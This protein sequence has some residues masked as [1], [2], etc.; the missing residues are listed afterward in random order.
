MRRTALL[1][2]FLL[3]VLT[4][5]VRGQSSGDIFLQ[6]R[7]AWDAGDY[8]SALEGF[9]EVLRGPGESDHREE[10]ALITGELYPV[11]AIAP[12]GRSLYL[13]PGGRFAAWNAPDDGDTRVVDISD[14]DRTVYEGAVQGLVFDHGDRLAAIT[15]VEEN[16]P[17]REARRAAN[18]ARQSG[19][20]RAYYQALGEVRRLEAVQARLAVLDLTTGRLHRV[21]LGGAIPTG[22]VFA[23]DGSALYIT[24]V[25]GQDA[26]HGVVLSVAADGRGPVTMVAEGA[27]YPSDPVALAGGFVAYERGPR[28]SVQG[29]GVPAAGLSRGIGL[30]DISRGVERMLPGEDPVP[31]GD[32]RTLVW[33]RSREAG[34]SF[35][36]LRA[37]W[38]GE[39]SVF[40]E[41]AEDVSSPTLSPSGDRMVFQMMA[42]HNW[43]LYIVPTAGGEAERLTYE[44]QHD[45][46]PRFLDEGTVFA[47][48]GE[49]RHRRSYLYDAADGSRR[50]LFHN[51][52]VRT[53]A[54]EYEWQVSSDGMRIL[55]GSERD[56]DTVSPERGVY[57]VDRSRTLGRE[58]ILKRVNA[59][60]ASERELQE[61][62][63]TMYAPIRERVAEVTEQVSMTM[64]YD[65]QADLY[66]FDSK[67]ITMP[68]NEPATR[69]IYEK[70]ASFGYEPEYHRFEV[71]RG[72]ET[73]R[74][75]NVLA[76]LEGTEHPEVVYVVSSHFDS[77]R[78]GPGADDNSTGAAVILE[79]ARVM[80]DQPQPATIVFAAFNGEEAG[81]LG[82]RA[83]V[84]HAVDNGLNL[85]GALNNDMFGWSGDH[86]LDNTIRYSN[87]GIRDVQHGAA[88]LFSGLITYDALYYKSTDAAA[89]YEAYG[90]IVGGIG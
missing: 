34:T 15:L 13:S 49:G 29:V 56:G 28:S 26:D 57:L 85:V 41:T 68:G 63:E 55:I 86:R 74:I 78:R 44:L 33:A 23:R 62:V 43:E 89:Y 40:F 65:Y 19:D 80:K 69:Y 75:A 48:M 77:N 54:P 90:D 82:S 16:A 3:F 5:S 25:P 50:R 45:L 10:I 88:M 2:L 51:N 58:A 47:V 87:A 84:Q 20:R 66:T 72:D 18:E 76:T 27:G 61:K 9:S 71:E 7:L 24:A 6:A 39:P 83:Y 79:A 4:S 31:S 52:T 35:S 42:W 60:L 22:T 46:N 11:R 1:S 36:I 37:P 32:G 14:G 59:Q 53:I 70:F 8:I 30:L 38:D 17:L 67:Y 81:L 12:D 73:L 21:D 64:L